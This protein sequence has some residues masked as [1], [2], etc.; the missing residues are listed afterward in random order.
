MGPLNMA[1]CGYG[2]GTMGRNPFRLDEFPAT[3]PARVRLHL[4]DQHA[5]ADLTSA[6][7]IVLGQH[8]RVGNEDNLWGADEALDLGRA[9]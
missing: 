8:V 9:G 7:A 6:M 4:L 2:G 3:G 1:I 5:R